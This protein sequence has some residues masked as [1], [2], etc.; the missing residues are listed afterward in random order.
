MVIATDGTTRVAGGLHWGDPEC[1]GEDHY[2]RTDTVLDWI[3]SYTGPTIVGEGP[4][5]CG[6]ITSVGRCLAS[7]S[8]AMW[9]GEDDTLENESCEG[10]TACGWDAGEGGFRCISGEDPCGGYDLFGA[11]VDGNAR[12]CENGV[13]KFRDCPSCGEV[14]EVDT[15]HGGAYCAPDPCEGIDFL[16][17]CEDNVAIWCQDGELNSV[18]CTERGE[19]CQFINDDIG[20]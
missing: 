2:A 11:C 8:V 13:P 4:Y 15:S 10:G 17:K 19:T 1:L 12:W 16:G 18:D 14:C 5:P 20:F 3:E 9:C 6:A 7:G